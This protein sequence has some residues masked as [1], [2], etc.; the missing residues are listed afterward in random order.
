MHQC[1]KVL[2][3]RSFRAYGT[4]NAGLSHETSNLST[5]ASFA[6]PYSDAL[7]RS[8]HGK[9]LDEP[10]IPDFPVIGLSPDTDFYFRIIGEVKWSLDIMLDIL[11]IWPDKD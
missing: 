4:C 10:L 9:S 2:N 8:Y 1:K 11:C 7:I 5:A 3:L 6:H